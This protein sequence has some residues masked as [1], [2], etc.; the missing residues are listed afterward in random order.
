MQDKTV[1]D[2]VKEDAKANF[3]KL[4]GTD[5]NIR[6]SFTHDKAGTEGEYVY[7]VPDIPTASTL[8]D[9]LLLEYGA[10]M[11][12]GNT[13]ASGKD[14]SDGDDKQLEDLDWATPVYL[15]ISVANK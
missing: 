12:E 4:S 1:V 7:N 14:G 9:F 6:F 2:I 11:D 15:K 10:K 5:Q 3:S 13:I 8:A